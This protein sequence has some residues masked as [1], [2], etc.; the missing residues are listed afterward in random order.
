MGQWLALAHEAVYLLRSIAT[1]I[2]AMRI[3]AERESH[4]AGGSLLRAHAEILEIRGTAQNQSS[5]RT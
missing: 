2:R 4:D 3:M 5:G 1:D